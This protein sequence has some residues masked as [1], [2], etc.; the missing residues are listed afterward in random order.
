MEEGGKIIFLHIPK[1]L[2]IDLSITMDVVLVWLAGL[3]TFLLLFFACR[4]KGLHAHG[5][6]QNFFESIIE[7]IDKEVAEGVMGLH[8][9][10]WS[11]FI[12]TVFFFILFCNLMGL[13]PVPGTEEH[14]IFKPV[15]SNINVTLTMAAMVFIVSQFVDMWLHGIGGY[16]MRVAPKGLPWWI[17]PLIFPLELIS[18]IARPVSLTLR[19]F[20]NMLAGHKIIGTFIGLGMLLSMRLFPLKIL[21]FVGSVVMM[22]FELF[23]CFVQAFIFSMLSAVYIDEALEEA[24]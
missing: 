11:P 9:K 21:P 14:P 16:F 7:F 22:A 8:G 19:L 5:G 12:L 4:R 15:T 24:H 13:V 2:G 6:Y 20:A 23:V 17:M 3:T 18:R 1:I 10:R